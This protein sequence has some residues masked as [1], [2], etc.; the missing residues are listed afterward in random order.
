MPQLNEWGWIIEIS[1]KNIPW[2]GE[3]LGGWE[4]AS[5]PLAP[6]SPASRCPNRPWRSPV[7]V[8]MTSQPSLSEV[9]A[10]TQWHLDRVQMTSRPSPDD[11][12]TKSR[13]KSQ[14]FFDWV[15]TVSQ[16][17]PGNFSVGS[18]QY[19]EDLRMISSTR[20]MIYEILKWK[21]FL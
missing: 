3:I 18:W 8:L 21:S 12:P 9:S 10:R 4:G 20:K 13:A 7:R 1:R 17:S 15:L 14:W 19:L 16:S 5:T 6:S 2:V 11:V